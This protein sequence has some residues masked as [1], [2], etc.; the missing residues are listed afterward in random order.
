MKKAK[1][2]YNPYSGDRSFRFE[3]DNVLERL[4]LGG[5]EVT[6]YRT[7]SI[8]DIYQSFKESKDY[9]C[10]IASG[11][12][13]TLNHVINSMVQNGLRVPLG[14]IPSGTSNDF[15]GHINIPKNIIKACEI[16]SGGKT[17]EF[18]L[19]LINGRY[20]VNVASA[21]LL[22][23]VS[24]KID[25]NMKNTLGKLAYYIKGIEQIPSFR[26]IPVSIEHEGKVIEEMIYFF[27]I[28]NGSTAG[29]FK[30]APDSTAN[31][32]TLNLVAVKSCSIV[33]LFNLFIKMLK[34]DHLE[35]NNVIYLKGREF[36]INCLENI[37]TDID[38]ESGPMFPLNIG[39][40]PKKL[41]IFVP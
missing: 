26:P 23:D 38:G 15:A 7:T 22:T 29:G 18:D 12:D 4:Q 20:F 33:E 10:V 27:V 16:I 39:I 32:G 36:K 11:G 41:K 34:G 2:I 40:V 24:Q 14:I 5:Y 6:P 1:I 3:L 30:L 8:E 37:E 28:L 13:G 25:I 35:S 9:D 17:T 21:G 31:D 19:G